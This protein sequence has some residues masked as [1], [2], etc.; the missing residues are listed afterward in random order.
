MAAPADDDAH[1]WDIH[2]GSEKSADDNKASDALAW[3]THDD[4]DEDEAPIAD[5]HKSCATTESIDSLVLPDAKRLKTE[6]TAATI[7]DAKPIQ[8]PPVLEGD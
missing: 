5:N 8:Q 4:E 7:I 6:V 2:S 3:D 1:A